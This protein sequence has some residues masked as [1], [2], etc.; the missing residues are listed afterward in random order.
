VRHGRES[1]QQDLGSFNSWFF[2]DAEDD[3]GHW[4][5]ALRNQP[6]WTAISALK[7]V[8]IT[9]CQERV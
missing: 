8:V 4:A 5:Q 2:H 3:L 1:Q 9:V 6:V 7:P